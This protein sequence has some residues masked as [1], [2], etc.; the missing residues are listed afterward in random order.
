MFIIYLSEAVK[1]III[2]PIKEFSFACLE[3]FLWVSITLLL[4]HI[5]WEIIIRYHLIEYVIKTGGTILRLKHNR[6][7]W[8][9]SW[10]DCPHYVHSLHFLSPVSPSPATQLHWAV[11]ILYFKLAVSFPFVSLSALKLLVLF[12]TPRDWAEFWKHTLK[13]IF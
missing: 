12:Q 9:P 5:G 7:C 3:W 4:N 13:A 8:L 2:I 6:A 11:E 1:D 10:I